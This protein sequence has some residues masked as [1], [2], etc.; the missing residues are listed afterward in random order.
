MRVRLR[1]RSRV[2]LAAALFVLSAAALGCV[3]EDDPG[4]FQSG[5]MKTMPYFDPRY[6]SRDRE[7]TYSLIGDRE[8]V[9][10]G[11]IDLGTEMEVLARSWKWAVLTARRAKPTLD[12]VTMEPHERNEIRKFAEE[13][14]PNKLPAEDTRGG[15]ELVRHAIQILAPLS[16]QRDKVADAPVKGQASIIFAKVNGDMLWP[17]GEVPFRIENGTP[18]EALITEAIEHWR[19]RTGGRIKF[20]RWNG[21]AT[22]YVVF[23]KGPFCASQWVGRGGGMQTV[24]LTA[25]STK[26]QLI[27]ELGHVVGLF[28]EQNRL[29]RDK[30][31]KIDKT[32]VKD[33]FVDQFDR[34]AYLCEDTAWDGGSSFDWASIMLYPPRAFSK[35][36]QQTMIRIGREDDLD[37]GL[38]SGPEYGGVTTELS[39]GDVEAI[40][41]L[42]GP[43]QAK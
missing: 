15:S 32:H 10:D 17:R 29:D 38:A 16:R 22:D 30:Q 1:P 7:L 8:V 40:K 9:V 27:H 14:D 41:I 28:H 42:Y 34:S 6:S 23:R 37:W 26:A 18:G 33:N 13:E 19:A 4:L 20:V 43:P 21:R 2:A 24:N 3:V 12:A 39:P 5:T 11:D 25:A 35:D 31:L 36:K